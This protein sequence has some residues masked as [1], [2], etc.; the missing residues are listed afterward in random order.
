MKKITPADISKMNYVQL[1]AN[2]NEVN[3]P[4][5]GKKSVGYAARNAFI[6]SDSKVLDVGCNTGF[7][8]F[9]IAHLCKANVLGVDISPEMI[10]AANAYK[11]LDPLKQLVNFQVADGMHLPFKDESYD[12][13]FSGGST[14]FID[15]KQKALMEYAR[16]TK[17]WGFVID[18]NF[19]YHK[20]P[21]VSLLK[22]LN[23][24]M[25]INIEPWGLDYWL[26]LYKNS[27][28]EL[29]QY[30]T[31]KVELVSKNAITEYSKTLVKDKGYS[32]E[33][34]KAVIKRLVEAMSLFNKNHRYLSYG[35]FINRK[36]S[37]KEQVTLFDI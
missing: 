20:K 11:K 36:R 18:I 10:S 17:P 9:E 21:S 28:L 33:T 15:D 3:R 30:H 31:D 26:D 7:C 6:N 35:V 22:Q 32:L 19:F 24:L 4:P 1:M 16:L 2:I 29:Y 12:V 27:D 34:E 23:D 13:V 25:E 37:I 8:T 14:A 5:G